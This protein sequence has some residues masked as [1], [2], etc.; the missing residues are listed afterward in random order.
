MNT[1]DHSNTFPAVFVMANYREALNDLETVGSRILAENASYGFDISDH[2]ALALR[3]VTKDTDAFAVAFRKM[4]LKVATLDILLGKYKEYIANEPDDSQQRHVAGLLKEVLQNMLDT[5]TSDAS[6]AAMELAALL[7]SEIATQNLF[8]KKVEEQL[9]ISNAIGRMRGLR[10]YLQSYPDFDEKFKEELLRWADNTLKTFSSGTMSVA[11]LT[12]ERESIHKALDYYLT[13][14][15]AKT[16]K[17]TEDYNT[18]HPEQVDDP[19]LPDQ[20]VVP[21]SIFSFRDRILSASDPVQVRAGLAD[22]RSFPSTTPDPTIRKP[23]N[24]KDLKRE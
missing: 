8:R 23:R 9:E 6:S 22:T 16:S 19:R 4:R 15:H 11:W 21:G 7:N 1:K 12:M 13:E 2:Y 5:N 14:K 24:K 20:P 3:I 18:S 10:D 17:A